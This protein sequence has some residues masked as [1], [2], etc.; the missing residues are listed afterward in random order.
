MHTRGQLPHR[1][2]LEERLEELEE[3]AQGFIGKLL[4]ESWKIHDTLMEEVW[5]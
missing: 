4:V 5:G 3:R 2:V 1:E